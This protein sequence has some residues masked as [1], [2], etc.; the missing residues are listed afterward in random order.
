MAK[1]PV[2]LVCFDVV[3]GEE[4]ITKKYNFLKDMN[5]ALEATKDVSGNR[6]RELAELAESGEQQLISKFSVSPSGIFCSFL[7]L[8]AGSASLITNDLFTKPSFS[9]SD[10]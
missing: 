8:K 6:A 9:F 3:P 1:K 7:H 2:R 4:K 10:I 5:E